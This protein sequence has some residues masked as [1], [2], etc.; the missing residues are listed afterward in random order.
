M[1]DGDGGRQDKG[2]AGYVPVCCYEMARTGD[3]T[4]CVG[5]WERLWCPEVLCQQA[6]SR[7][8]SDSQCGGCQCGHAFNTYCGADKQPI[9]LAQR[10]GVTQAPSNTPP[11]PTATPSLTSVPHTAT[12]VPPTATSSPPSNTPTL[13]P[14][15]PTLSSTPPSATPT[16]YVPTQQPTPLPGQ[17]GQPSQPIF[18]TTIPPIQPSSYDPPPSTMPT[19]SAGEID[20]WSPPVS[21][22]TIEFTSPREVAREIV[23]IE[24]VEKLNQTTEVPLA[25]VKAGVMK[26][27]DVDHELEV[28]VQSYLDILFFKVKTLWNEITQ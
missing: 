6:K 5:Y 10:L 28:F 9:P 13:P 26:V 21:F 19:A 2:C 7:G 14:N 18:P 23:T 16:V 17:S 25:A 22:P 11:P 1:G 8:A 4:K 3:F 24:R 20:L 12:P 15:T 27:K